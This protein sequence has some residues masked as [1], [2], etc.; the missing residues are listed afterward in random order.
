MQSAYAAERFDDVFAGN[1]YFLA[2]QQDDLVVFEF[3]Q[4]PDKTF[5]G[6]ASQLGQLSPGQGKGKILGMVDGLRKVEDD[7]GNATG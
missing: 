4:G 3:G 1:L 5:F 7:V 6:R 2:L